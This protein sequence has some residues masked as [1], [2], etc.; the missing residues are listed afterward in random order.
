[1]VAS[2]TKNRGL[3]HRPPIHVA[4]L[5]RWMFFFLTPMGKVGTLG[6]KHGEVFFW[7]EWRMDGPVTLVGRWDFFF[8]FLLGGY[9]PGNDHIFPHQSTFELMIFLFPLGGIS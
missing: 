1:M 2:V 7:K 3:E 5:D 6:K 8:P 9:L 4:W